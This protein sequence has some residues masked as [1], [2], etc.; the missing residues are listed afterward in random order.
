MKNFL[1][2]GAAKGIGFGIAS[3]LRAQGHRVLLSARNKKAGEEA[4]K[5]V[6]ADFIQMDVSDV[7]SIRRAAAE[8]Q[9]L[10]DHLDGLVNNAGVLLDDGIPLI[11]ASPELVRTTMDTNALGPFFVVQ[12]FLPLLKPGSRVVNVSSGG[13]SISEG[14]AGWAPVYC[15]SKTALSGITLQLAHA[16]RSEKISVNAMCPGWVRTDMGGR[17]APRSV[18]QG[19]DTAVWLL[20]EASA[21]LTG[22][23]FRDRKEIG[24]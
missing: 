16:L 11:K 1:V 18:E 14:V 5:K 9:Q 19:A 6:G 22:K 15:F 7:N 13:G 24:W 12:A 21:K 20:T 4:A 8:T 10:M 3:A 17:G 23:N 2:T